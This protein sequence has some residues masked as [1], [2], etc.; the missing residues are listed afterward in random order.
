MAWVQAIDGSG[1]VGNIVLEV[2]P[3]EDPSNPLIDHITAPY[4]PSTLPNWLKSEPG[5]TFLPGP[6]A[7][8]EETIVSRWQTASCSKVD[9]NGR[10]IVSINHIVEFYIPPSAH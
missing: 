6:P 5:A 7:D 4:E 1:E 2:A 9:R 8:H 10:H 3:T